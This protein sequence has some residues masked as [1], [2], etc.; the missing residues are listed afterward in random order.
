VQVGNKFWRLVGQRAQRVDLAADPEGRVPG[1]VPLLASPPGG[2]CAQIAERP[3]AVQGFSSEFYEYQNICFRIDQGYYA[4][5]QVTQPGRPERNEINVT[6]LPKPSPN[7]MLRALTNPPAP[8]SKLAPFARLL[9]ADAERAEGRW[10]LGTS[11]PHAGWLF[12][13]H[14]DS[15]GELR[16][17][18]TP[19]STC[20]LWRLGLDVQAANVSSSVPSGAAKLSPA[21]KSDAAPGSALSCALSG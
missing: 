18:G 2:A 21:D 9:P 8:I 12:V 17:V 5:G 19:W 11:G 7:M 16:Y 14:T 1:L 20:A 10:W 4:D 6:V 15:K 13:R 3:L